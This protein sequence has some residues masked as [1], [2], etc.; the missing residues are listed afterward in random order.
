MTFL[1][2]LGILILAGVLNHLFSFLQWYMAVNSGIK[3]SLGQLFRMRKKGMPVNVLLDNLIKARQFNIDVTIE[4]LYL[5]HKKGGDVYNLVDG[6]VRARRYGLLI[7]FDR[8]RKADLM[9]IRL[10]EAVDIIAQNR[11]LRLKRVGRE[12]SAQAKAASLF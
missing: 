2:I 7:P 11:G 3:I 9:K 8:A 12:I 5:H 6:L 10:P 4:Q 1:V